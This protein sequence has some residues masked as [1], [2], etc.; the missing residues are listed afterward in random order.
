MTAH[1]RCMVYAAALAILAMTLACDS[2]LRPLTDR[3]DP[4][5]AHLAPSAA[6]TILHHSDTLQGPAAIEV[7]G[8]YLVVLDSY[9][10]SA[11][12]VFA[13]ASGEY[14]YSFGRKGEG[15]GE[16]KGAWSVLPVSS[17]S[18]QF[19][20]FDLALRRL[21]LFD[22]ATA[23]ASP[24]DMIALKVPVTV[25]DPVWISDDR[26]VALAFSGAGRLAEFDRFGN[27]LGSFGSPPGDST[28]APTVVR[29]QAYVGTL[30]ARPDTALLAIGTRYASLIEGLRP[31]GTPTFRVHGPRVFAPQY[32]VRGEDMVS[33]D[34]MR[35]GY[36]DLAATSKR[37][38]GLYSGR[39]RAEAPGAAF[40]GVEV[41][42]F[43]WSGVLER[44]LSIDGP[45]ISIAVDED[46]EH[47][48][49][50]RELPT[51]AILRYPLPM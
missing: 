43:S 7:V 34:A 24:V 40:L 26:L 19:W 50:L 49:V 28:Q 17:T 15:P 32:S 23:D 14:L 46:R 2:R 13:R 5:L 16:C 25:V 9:A 31:D 35:F 11:V 3:E 33:D 10:D 44:R 22:A 36:V 1:F 30:V 6:P 45:A 8:E 51:P 41:H 47:L 4:Q 29:Q 18:S 12:K 21:T 27:H 37:I 38:Y 20:V 48:Y 39:T 42:I